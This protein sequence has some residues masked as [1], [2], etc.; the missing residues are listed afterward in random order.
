MHG[1]LIPSPSICALANPSPLS[2]KHSSSAFAD[3]CWGSAI[4]KVIIK[5]QKKGTC[6]ECQRG[7]EQ[8]G[9]KSSKISQRSHLILYFKPR[10]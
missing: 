9:T 4:F 3:G 1:C 6:G 5:P 8:E 2:D 10:S 7:K